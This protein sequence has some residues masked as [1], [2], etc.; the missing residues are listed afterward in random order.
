MDLEEGAENVA[1]PVSQ[2]AEKVTAT[3]PVAAGSAWP[4]IATGIGLGS[5]GVGFW[6]SRALGGAAR[7][8][9]TWEREGTS[10]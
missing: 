10:L 8:R 4:A 1:L 2:A 3:T 7:T 5:V 9:K 6:V